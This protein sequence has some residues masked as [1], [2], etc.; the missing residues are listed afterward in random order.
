MI[1]LKYITIILIAH[2]LADFFQSRKV[3]DN[4]HKCFITLLKHA[5]KYTFIFF[6]V[7]FTIFSFERFG[8]NVFS[9]KSFFLLDKIFYSCILYILFNGFAHLV[10]DFGTSK[11]THYFHKHSKIMLFFSTIGFDQM[12][13]SLILLYSFY[14]IVL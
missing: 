14:Y 10:V 6:L 9:I 11:T 8:L 12:I 5:S 2:F 1:D 3:A 13:H 7:F 4:K